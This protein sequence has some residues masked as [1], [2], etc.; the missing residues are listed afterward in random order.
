MLYAYSASGEKI[1]AL[2]SWVAVC[3]ECGSEV[4]AKCGRINIWHWAHKNFSLCD[5]WCES[6][7]EWHLY[8]KSKFP[9]EYV[10][11]PIVMVGERHRADVRLPNG[12]VIEFQHSS[13]SVGDIWIREAFYKNVIWIF[14]LA[15]PYEND[16][17][18]F[19]EKSNYVTFRWKHPRKSI[20]H[21]R[22]KILLDLGNELFDVRKI[23]LDEYCGGW[24]SFVSYENFLA[25]AYSK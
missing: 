5:L 14:D 1:R 2:P 3:P 15:E 24:G 4:I 10:E 11:V 18:L 8:W 9:K 25:W 12:T 19:D 22:C 20:A 21:A 7:T 6:E 17:I 13:L 16:Q 23:Y